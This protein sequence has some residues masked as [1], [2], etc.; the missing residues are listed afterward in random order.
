[1]CLPTSSVSSKMFIHRLRIDEEAM[2]QTTFLYAVAL[3]YGCVLD[4]YAASVVR[5]LSE[6]E[7]V[8]VTTRW[9]SS[10][11]VLRVVKRWSWAREYVNVLSARTI[12]FPVVELFTSLCLTAV[13]VYNGATL[14]ALALT[15]VLST[16]V[17][18]AATDIELLIYP[19]RLSLPLI[20]AGIVFAVLAWPLAGLP[21]ALDRIGGG[22]VGF[23]TTWGSSK[24][25]YRIRRKEGLGFGDVKMCTAIGLFLGFTGAWMFIFA[26]ALC[27]S[28]IGLLLVFTRRA[29]LSDEFPTGGWYV[30]ALAGVLLFKSTY[31]DIIAEPSTRAP[32][33]VETVAR[34]MDHSSFG[35][36]V[37]DAH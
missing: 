32:L 36:G 25:Y 30:L 15:V 17:I 37:R 3:L 7:H 12:C 10:W 19:D 16:L 23:A 21:D 13:I 28:I 29:S 18:G 9:L 22:A 8:N 33:A 1:V 26:W 20:G 14:N 34:C 6:A 11:G 24:L 4:V 2:S 5:L 31:L 35:A 27:G